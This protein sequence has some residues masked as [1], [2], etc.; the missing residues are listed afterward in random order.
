[1]DLILSQWAVGCQRCEL[2][3]RSLTI[4][5]DSQLGYA[6]Q[7][8]AIPHVLYAESDKTLAGV[9]NF[10]SVRGRS[11]TPLNEMMTTAHPELSGPHPVIA[12]AARETFG[13]NSRP[14]CR[15]SGSNVPAAADALS[16]DKAPY[17]RIFGGQGVEFGR[18][19]EEDPEHG[20]RISLHQPR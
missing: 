9:T 16:N 17:H 20:P 18:R 13:G 15:S 4:R 5:L 8:G 12:S 10:V 3:S 6:M 14:R 19:L 7:F 1:L 11:N 2:P